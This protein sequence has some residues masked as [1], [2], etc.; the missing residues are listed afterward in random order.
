MRDQIKNN[1]LGN[2]YHLYEGSLSEVKIIKDKLVYR[3]DNS[4]IHELRPKPVDDKDL[5]K[6]NIYMVENG[7]TVK[8]LSREV[9]EVLSRTPMRYDDSIEELTDKQLVLFWVLVK[10]CENGTY[11]GI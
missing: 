9:Y 5:V 4:N 1:Y 3:N 10:N 7:S 6:G 11:F 2:F 8:Y